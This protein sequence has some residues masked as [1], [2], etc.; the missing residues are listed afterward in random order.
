MILGQKLNLNHPSLVDEGDETRVLVTAHER[1]SE[2]KYNELHELYYII[3]LY[4]KRYLDQ[5]YQALNI[6]Q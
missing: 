1:K 4:H 6:F 2:I 3:M 5:T